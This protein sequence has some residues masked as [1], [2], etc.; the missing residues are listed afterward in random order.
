MKDMEDHPVA[1]VRAG[2]QSR[3]GQIER[4]GNMNGQ[5]EAW[6]SL[7]VPVEQ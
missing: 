2:V 7:Y 1:I 3:Y 6:E 4:Q 5:A